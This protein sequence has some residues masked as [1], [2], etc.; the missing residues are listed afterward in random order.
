MIDE[1]LKNAYWIKKSSKLISFVRLGNGS[2]VVELFHIEEKSKNYLLLYEKFG[3]TKIDLLS[4][5]NKSKVSRDFNSQKEK[6]RDVENLGI[7]SEKMD[8]KSN[9]ILK[10][11]LDPKWGIKLEEKEEDLEENDFNE[12][13]KREIN[14]WGG[15]FSKEFQ[16]DTF[17]LERHPYFKNFKSKIKDALKNQ[18]GSSI[19]LYRGIY[20]DQVKDVLKNKKIKLHKFS[21][22]TSDKSIA[23]Y[24]IRQFGKGKI[25][26]IVEATFKLDNILFA[27]VVL[28]D[29]INKNILLEQFNNEKEFIVKKPGSIPIKIHSKTKKKIN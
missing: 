17:S 16:G 20:G 12:Y 19:K 29:Y 9:K 1:I 13:L 21:S 2:F 7:D 14:K 5:G 28:H 8:P 6:Y 3:S 24:I 18:Y 25:W 23:S 15:S 22:W 26:V 11:I 4:S 27:P 10:F